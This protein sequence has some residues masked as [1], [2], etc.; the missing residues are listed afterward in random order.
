MGK[1]VVVALFEDVLYE[2]VAFHYNYARAVEKI[3]DIDVFVVL[4]VY[5]YLGRISTPRWKSDFAR[6][7][8]RRDMF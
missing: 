7:G 5:D 6:G 4:L 1:I 3:R 8:P 2:R